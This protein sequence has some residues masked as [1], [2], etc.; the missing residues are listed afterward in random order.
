MNAFI[1]L[2][3][4]KLCFRRAVYCFPPEVICLR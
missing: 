2:A 1:T 4:M 3:D